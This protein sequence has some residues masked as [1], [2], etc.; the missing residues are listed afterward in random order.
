MPP[1]YNIKPALTLILSLLFGYACGQKNTIPG[2]VSTPYPTLINIGIDW[3]IKGDDN[4]NG[5]VT[6]SFREKGKQEWRKGM[7]LRRVPAGHKYGFNWTNKHS[8]SIFD[9]TPG[10]LY[11][12][13]LKLFDPDGGST[14]RIVDASTRPEPAVDLNAELIDLKPGVYDTL[15]TKSGSKEH[16]VVY[17]CTGGSATYEYID[18]S[19]REWVY[20]EGLNVVNLKVTDIE[21]HGVGIQMDGATNCAISRCTINSVYGIVADKPGAINC[22][23][24]DNVITGINKWTNE[25]MG[26][27][28]KNIGEGIQI[29]GSG[30]VICYNRVTGFRDCIST[31]E[32]SRATEQYGFDIY[33]NDIETGVDDGIESDFCI[34]NCRIFRNRITNCY[35]GISSQPG[36]GG[37]N[38][39]IR[40]V[41]YN[42]IHGAFKLKRGSSG[43][44]A[45]HNTIIKVG[46]GL[47]CND[48]MDFEYFRNNL[49]FGGENGNRKW[50]GYGSGNP[51]GT[52][53]FSPGKH[54]SYD[55]DAVG[56]FGTEYKSTIGDRSFAS[57]EPH[58][59]EKIL[60]DEIF[61]DVVF[62]EPPVP[63]KKV[64]VLRPRAGS[65]V[66]DAGVMI[67]NVNDDFTGTAPD[68]GAY[69][70][71]QELPHYGP[72]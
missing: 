4:L 36:L 12:I 7:D 66:I 3:N 49:V 16:P 15:E 24:S 51:S 32:D 18:L 72:R 56:V 52:E 46:A 39:F 2:E 43:D 59:I 44:V 63:E 26:A 35:V 64:P 17:T 14:E 42:V 71:G 48:P 11:E 45:L 65:K 61:Q 20:I 21:D 41:M 60:L 40:N 55:Y 47:G 25:S 37:P 19:H 58:G 9:L 57:V 28:G 6:V 5:I 50:G 67:P 13:K 54:S 34:S 68:C 69:E 29:T 53:V 70:E 22:Y 30:N 8:G 10:T 62:P 1:Q 31:M 33:N 38:Y 27:N 23:I